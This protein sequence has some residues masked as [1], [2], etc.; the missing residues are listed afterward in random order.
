MLEEPGRSLEHVNRS[1]SNTASVFP[2]I[3]APYVDSSV[4]DLPESFLNALTT[5]KGKSLE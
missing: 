5:A 3:S 4:F 2:S 1:F